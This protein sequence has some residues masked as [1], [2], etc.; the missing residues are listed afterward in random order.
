[1]LKDRLDSERQTTVCL[2]EASAGACGEDL[3]LT[4]QV[5][6]PARCENAHRVCRRG[7]NI[8]RG[9][10]KLDIGEDMPFGKCLGPMAATI[11][12]E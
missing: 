3:S 6:G 10:G 4:M 9:R 11:D 2:V 1:M 8:S 12:V 7:K 5:G